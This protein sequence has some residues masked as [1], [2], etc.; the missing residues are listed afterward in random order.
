[1]QKVAEIVLFHD[2]HL[3]NLTYHKFYRK[4][5]ITAY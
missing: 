3:L 2:F 1:M 5:I 4:T